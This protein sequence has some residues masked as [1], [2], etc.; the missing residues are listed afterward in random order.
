MSARLF[1][2]KDCSLE[3]IAG[4]TIVFIGYGNQGRAQALNLWLLVVGVDGEDRHRMPLLRQ[5]GGGAAPELLIL[6]R[7]EMEFLRPFGEVLG[8]ETDLP[9]TVRAGDALGVVA[10]A[11]GFFAR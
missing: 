2:D 7:R 8:F 4:K 6:E 3:P 11:R 5:G 1:Y 9:R 10:G